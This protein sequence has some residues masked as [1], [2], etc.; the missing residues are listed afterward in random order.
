MNFSQLMH[1]LRHADHRSAEDHAR[2]AL[3]IWL[4][5]LPDGQTAQGAARN[6]LEHIVPQLDPTES[7]AHFVKLLKEVAVGISV[8]LPRRRRRTVH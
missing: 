4:V 1:K 5:S 6:C 7:E 3:I 2:K 8:P